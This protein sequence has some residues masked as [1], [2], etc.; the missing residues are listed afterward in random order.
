MWFFSQQANPS[1]TSELPM[2]TEA[3]MRS[4]ADLLSHSRVWMSIN[5]ILKVPFLSHTCLIIHDLSQMTDILTLGISSR[6]D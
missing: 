5:Y 1:L 2:E 3:H 6:P 4:L